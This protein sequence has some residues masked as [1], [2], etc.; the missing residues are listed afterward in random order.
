[1]SRVRPG[2]RINVAMRPLWAVA[3]TGYL[4]QSEGA[5]VARWEST[6]CIPVTVTAAETG[7]RPASHE[8][9]D[10][11]EKSPDHVRIAHA[12]TRRCKL[13]LERRG[14]VRLDTDQVWRP[15]ISEWTSTDAGNGGVNAT[16]A[17]VTE[18]AAMSTYG[19]EAAPRHEGLILC[20]LRRLMLAP[21]LEQFFGRRRRKPGIV[22]FQLIEF[23]FRSFS[24]EKI[25]LQQGS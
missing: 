16:E 10:C 25:I 19:P 5:I 4:H 9:S 1:M 14:F 11:C 12:Q 15:A 17:H 18:H 6:L 23:I 22:A 21:K 20:F 13:K 7:Q 24:P 8:T 2:S 3:I